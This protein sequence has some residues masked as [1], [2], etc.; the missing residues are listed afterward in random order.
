MAEPVR[1]KDMP[2]LRSLADLEAQITAAEARRVQWLRMSAALTAVGRASRREQAILR[3]TEERLEQLRPS[4]H[5]TEP[6]CTPS[7]R[8]SA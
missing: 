2:R 1:L 3:L 8:S 4:R 6:S 7:T 5:P